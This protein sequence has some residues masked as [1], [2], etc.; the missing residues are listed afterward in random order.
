MP[1][2]N[3]TANDAA[4]EAA[5]AAEE[6]SRSAEPATDDADARLA[7]LEGELRRTQNEVLK[8]QAEFENFRKRMRREMEE[9]SRYAA[10]PLIAELL[11][12]IDNLERA[13]QAAEQT[14]NAGPLLDGVHMV[15]GQ[16]D[17]ALAKSGC[18]KIEALG[19]EFDPHVH[20]ALRQEPNAEHPAGHVCRVLQSGYKLH[21]RV[22]RP[23]QVFVSTGPAQ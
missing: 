18:Q 10:L 5:F 3:T 19:Q 8:G 21:D 12:V 16:F 7:Q 17:A 2:H 23:A 6:K 1:D 4:L 15:I 9:E 11:P 20:M 22:I 14:G 13:T